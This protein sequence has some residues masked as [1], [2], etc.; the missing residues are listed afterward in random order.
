MTGRG[1]ERHAGDG[2]GGGRRARD[3]GSG[4]V[5]SAKRGASAARVLQR[6][7][8]AEMRGDGENRPRDSGRD[9]AGRGRLRALPP[10]PAGAHLSHPDA[11]GEGGG[12][13]QNHGADAGRGRLCNQAVSTVGAR[14]ARQGAASAVYALQRGH[15]RPARERAGRARACAQSGYAYVYAERTAAEADAD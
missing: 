9:A 14:G 15:G 7:G 11:D 13:R 3:C 5:L 1:G 2:A 12:N 8:R 10:H 6:A 4:G